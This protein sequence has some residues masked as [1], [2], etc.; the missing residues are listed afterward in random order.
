M[1]NV[2]P[3]VHSLEHIHENI[4][5]KRVGLHGYDLDNTTWRRVAVSPDGSLKKNYNQYIVE[6]GSITY[7]GLA[8]PGTSLDSAAWQC[9]K[10]DASLPGTTHITWADGDDLFNNVASNITSLSYS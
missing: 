7:L 2:T 5:A 10:I 6:S 4:H 9:R 3:E 1:P 8:A